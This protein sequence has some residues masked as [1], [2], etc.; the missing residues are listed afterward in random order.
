MQ[1]PDLRANPAIDRFAKPAR[2]RVY[3]QCKVCVIP[4]HSA[5]ART[6]GLQLQ[7]SSAAWTFRR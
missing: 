6:E 5:D 3:P 7:N 2:F 4:G 1:A